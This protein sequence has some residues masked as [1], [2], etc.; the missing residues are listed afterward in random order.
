MV[1]GWTADN[2][3]EEFDAEAY[4]TI[5]CLA[6]GGLHLVKSAIGRCSGSRTIRKARAGTRE[7]RLHRSGS[8]TAQG[9]EK[10]REGCFISTDF[11]LLLFCLTEP[12]KF[13]AH[14]IMGR[15]L[16]DAATD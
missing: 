6:C 15:L 13:I 11:R 14:S 7:F 16:G 8:S 2:P 9:G 10:R 12:E 1:R 4:E 3:A 5:E